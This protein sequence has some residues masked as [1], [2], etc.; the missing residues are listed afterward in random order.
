[1]NVQPAV[2]FGPTPSVTLPPTGGG[3]F[4]AN[5]ASF[6]LLG[7]LETKAESVS[8]QGVFGASGFVASSAQAATVSAAGRAVTASL[9]ATSCRIDAA[10]NTTGT[11]SFASLTVLGIPVSAS[12]P[13]NAVI[14]LPGVGTLTLNEQTSAIGPGGH[15]SITVNGIHLHLAGVLGTGD[16]FVSQSRCIAMI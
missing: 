11:T 1:V 10:G 7:L 5:L 16:I 14:P 8:T 9:V 4:T 3:P 13:A 15:R 12:P 6:V 2:T